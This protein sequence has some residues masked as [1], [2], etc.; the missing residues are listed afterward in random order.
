MSHG[1]HIKLVGY[2]ATDLL[3]EVGNVRSFL[4]ALVDKL[5]MRALGEPVM[6]DVPVELAKMNVEPFEDEGGVTGTVVLSTSHCAIHTWP[7]RRL[8]VLDVFSCRDFDPEAVLDLVASAFG[9]CTWNV[10]DISVTLEPPVHLPMP[11]EP[12]EPAD[13]AA[14]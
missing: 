5:K 6:F 10:T 12:A 8:F 7:A 11:S 9:P 3:S 13:P 4:L 14:N 1:R 2:G